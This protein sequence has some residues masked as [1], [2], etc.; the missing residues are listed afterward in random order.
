M[1]T[2]KCKFFLYLQFDLIYKLYSFIKIS[3]DNIKICNECNCFLHDIF[4]F[5]NKTKIIESMFIELLN[6]EEQQQVIQ[7]S[8]IEND[9]EQKAILET[10]ESVSLS[11]SCL[12]DIRNKFGLKVMEKDDDEQVLGIFDESNITGALEIKLESEIGDFED[13]HD[14]Q[15]ALS[16]E[17]EDTEEDESDIEEL[18]FSQIKRRISLDSHGYRDESSD[19]DRKE[20]RRRKKKYN[21]TEDE[22]LFE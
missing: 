17:T 21:K 2:S 9:T 16:E 5:V 12:N 10:Q 1:E 15:D 11:E 19:S 8:S 6:G 7:Q 20:R 18:S 14:E 4:T 22:I 3:A 13:E